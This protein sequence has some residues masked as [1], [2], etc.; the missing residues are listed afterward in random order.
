MAR[1]ITYTCEVCG[2]DFVSHRVRKRRLLCASCAA[3]LRRRGQGP[4]QLSRGRRDTAPT[5]PPIQTAAPPTTAN[6]SATARPSEKEMERSKAA[7]TAKCPACR[8]GT[9]QEVVERKLF[10]GMKTTQNLQC[11]SC[12]A[13]FVMHG[14]KYRLTKVDDKSLSV[15]REYGGKDLTKK[16]WKRIAYGGVSDADQREADIQA[17][18]KDIKKGRIEIGRFI[19]T[20]S[21]VILRR[22]EERLVVIPNMQL[23]EPRSVTRS[24]GVYGG[25]SFRI[26]KGITWRMGAFGSQSESHDELRAIDK[27]ILTVTNR[28]LVFVGAQRTTDVSIDRITAVDPYTDGIA[29]GTRDRT[30]V[31]YFV[32]PHLGDYIAHVT[33][34]GRKCSDQL[35]GLWLACVIIGITKR[36]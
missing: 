18:L 4:I 17:A 30:K 21:S 25:P 35:S 14:S 7:W 24:F 33:V 26:T 11:N 27:G 36:Q 16:E 31:Q 3:D 20:T 9:L 32:E 29:V 8:S 23:W 6:T 13:L 2:K 10:G 15:W 12:R 22:D 5:P 1:D 19:Y 34:N 28:R